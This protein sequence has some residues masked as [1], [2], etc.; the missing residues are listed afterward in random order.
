MESWEKAQVM[1]KLEVRIEVIQTPKCS[2]FYTQAVWFSSL[3]KVKGASD[4]PTW[5]EQAQPGED[6]DVVEI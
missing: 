5:R 4:L 2:G 1:I 3:G 6:S